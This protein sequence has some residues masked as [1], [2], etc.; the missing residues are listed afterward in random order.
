MDI[1]Y[2]NIEYKN[3]LPNLLT[4]EVKNYTEI[5]E[6]LLVLFINYLKEIIKIYNSNLDNYKKKYRNM[7]SVLENKLNED[8]CDIITEKFTKNKLNDIFT[9]TIQ[10]FM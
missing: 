6:M 2:N 5:S 3:K 1:N 7:I 8:V 9:E 10:T 4:D